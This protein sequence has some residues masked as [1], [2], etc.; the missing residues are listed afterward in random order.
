MQLEQHESNGGTLAGNAASA[1]AGRAVALHSVKRILQITLSLS[2]L[3]VAAFCVFG[4]DASFEV[5]VLNVFHALYGAVGI[6]SLAVAT[7]LLR[8]QNSTFKGF[9]FARRTAWAAL[10][11]LGL[12][13]LLWF[14]ATGGSHAPWPPR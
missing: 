10:F 6:L 12:A 1:S 5:G 2:L 4:F 9:K 14:C 13:L 3:A 11:F 8:G 7:G